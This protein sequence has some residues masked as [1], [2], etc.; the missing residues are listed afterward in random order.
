VI[1]RVKNQSLL[2]KNRVSI[3]F[4]ILLWFLSARRF[5][6][7]LVGHYA[8]AVLFWCCKNSPKNRSSRIIW[9]LVALKATTGSEG[10]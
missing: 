8:E 2:S 5:A 7:P 1:S 10:R 3:W 9:G 6:G 4:P